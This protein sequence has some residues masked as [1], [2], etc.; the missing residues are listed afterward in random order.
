MTGKPG[1]WFAVLLAVGLALGTQAHRVELE[2]N[3]M[4]ME[5]EGLESVELQDLMT[6]EFGSAPDVLFYL[7][8]DNRLLPE[9]VEALEDLDSVKSV[10]AVTQWLPTDEQRRR[11]LPYLKEIRN[12]LIIADTSTEPD[13]DALLE[14][15]YR[16]EANL[17]EM[18]DLAVLGGSDR[19]AY[20]LNRATG[21]NND[22]EKVRESVFDRLFGTLE[23]GTTD[24]SEAMEFQELFTPLLSQKVSAMAGT[25]AVSRDD[26][27]EMIR[28]SFFSKKR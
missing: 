24:S 12:Q 22:G 18:G 16:L 19:L 17:V 9:M 21:L 14:E 13:Q 11:R 3:L 10:N 20:V 8:E 7:S 6:D 4:E 23:T 28:N 25:T 1:L 5:A 15:L 2:D 26:L 27:P